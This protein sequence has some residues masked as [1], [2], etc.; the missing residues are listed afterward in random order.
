[1][2]TTYSCPCALMFCN[3]LYFFIFWNKLHFAIHISIKLLEGTL[4]RPY[5][6][7]TGGVQWTRMFLKDIC[8]VSG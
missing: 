5:R 7:N 6:I 4:G 1:M 3:E 8:I 2:Y